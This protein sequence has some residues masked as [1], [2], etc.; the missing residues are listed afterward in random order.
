MNHRMVAVAPP[1][2]GKQT[3][4]ICLRLFEHFTNID[5]H[6]VA[7]HL[8]SPAGGI[9]VKELKWLEQNTKFVHHMVVFAPLPHAKQIG[10]DVLN[11]LRHAQ[12]YYITW[13]SSHRFP[14]PRKLMDMIQIALTI[15]QHGP[16]HCCVRTASRSQADSIT[17]RDT[18][19]LLRSHRSRLPSNLI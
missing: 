10:F 8:I 19:T 15:Y 17:P 4:L 5:H 2:P 9:V 13:L 14:K 6:I 16:S 12:T 1:A 11:G 3:Y 18:T 7:F